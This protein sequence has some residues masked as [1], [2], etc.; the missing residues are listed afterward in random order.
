MILKKNLNK[1]DKYIYIMYRGDTVINAPVQFVRKFASD[2][3]LISGIFGLAIIGVKDKS[4][5]IFL[6]GDEIKQ[7]SMPSDEFKVVF[8]VR[9][10]SDFVFVTGT[11]KGPEI[12][13]DGI[14]YYG[15]SDDKKLEVEV[16]IVLKGL[17]DYTTR[18]YFEA[19]FKYK[20]SFMDRFLGRK[21]E[22]F[23]KYIV[24]D[25][26]VTYVKAYFKSF[27]ELLPEMEKS[28]APL[29]LSPIFEFSGD[30]VNI[31]AK[32]NELIA[33]LNVAVIKVDF[34]K[35]NCRI[36]AENKEM[37]KVMCKSEGKI[38][39]DFEALS[40]IMTARGQGKMEVYGMNTDQ[41]FEF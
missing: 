15:I 35:L 22:D 37:K 32:I 24:E 10:N 8:P 26:F 38:K 16:K 17:A 9:K 4:R 25:R 36:V 19:D 29:S 41:V 30:A 20:G 31:L 27:V 13:M 21:A 33:Q 6:Y 7:L 1:Q 40:M 14:R 12:L 34:D 2:P 18:V 39:S 3:V 11:W 28:S 23:A 5:D